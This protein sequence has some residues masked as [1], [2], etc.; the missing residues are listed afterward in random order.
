[1]QNQQP[2]QGRRKP[3][4]VGMLMICIFAVALVRFW[5]QVVSNP[6]ITLTKSNRDDDIHRSKYGRRLPSS[7]EIVIDR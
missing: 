3:R 4:L 7:S 6:T 5:I 1:M 2:Q